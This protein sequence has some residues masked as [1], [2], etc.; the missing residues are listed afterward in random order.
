M[1]LNATADINS[2]IEYITNH[3]ADVRPEVF[4]NKQLLDTIRLEESNYVHYRLADSSPIQGK[5][6]KLQLRR[7]APLKAHT[8][9]LAEGVPPTSDKGSMESYEISTFPYGRYMEF[10]DRVD[11]EII[12]PVIAHYTKEYNLVAMETL[13]IL[14]RDALLAVGQ[15]YFANDRANMAALEIGDTPSLD[16]LRVI[17]LSMK[18]Q[19]VK[20][21]SNGKFHVIASPDFFFDMISDPLVEK[22]MTFNNTTKPMYED[23]SLVP[24]FNMEFYETQAGD[25]SGEYVD[26]NGNLNLLVYRYNTNTAAYEYDVLDEATY[27]TETASYDVDGRTGQDASFFPENR[28]W[29]L[30]TYNASAAADGYGDFQELKVH[31]TLILG[32]DALIKTNISGGDSA[33]MYVKPLGS[34]GVLDPIDQRQSIGFKINGVG[35]GSP[36]LEAIAVYYNIPTQSNLY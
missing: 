1:N 31:R 5:A 30:A 20:P 16:D 26:G 13:D 12:D 19:L 24:M 15:S 10:T 9:P 7:W 28:S 32:K 18:K 25:E 14:A 4:Y 8:T 34:A 17:V 2:A 21:R 3:G 36:R 23:G 27:M 22:F 29:D 33:K 35:F 11:M 6:E